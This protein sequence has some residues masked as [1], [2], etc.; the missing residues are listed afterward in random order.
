VCVR[1]WD[2]NTLDGAKAWARKIPTCLDKFDDSENDLENFHQNLLFL[3]I[4]IDALI[5][6]CALEWLVT[7]VNPLV[8]RQSSRGSKRLPAAWVIT[9]IRFYYAKF[10]Y[11]K[12]TEA[13]GRHAYFRGYDGAYVAAGWQLQKSSDCTQCT[14]RAYVQYAT[15]TRCLS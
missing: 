11:I 15:E 1:S 5:A 3:V 4:T 12:R 2:K 8:D 10:E 9:M 14:E 7:I 13:E 6:V